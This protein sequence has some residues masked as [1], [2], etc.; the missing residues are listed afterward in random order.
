[1]SKPETSI[2]LSVR[3]EWQNR[4]FYL[5][6]WVFISPENVHS[7]V[8]IWKLEVGSMDFLQKNV[9]SCHLAQGKFDFTN[10]TELLRKLQSTFVFLILLK[11]QIANLTHKKLIRTLCIS[12]FNWIKMKTNTHLK[13]SEEFISPLSWQFKYYFIIII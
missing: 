4:L 11:S 6:R 12:W 13:Y 1:M 7:W 3:R 8:F 2:K 10:N 5:Q 9:M